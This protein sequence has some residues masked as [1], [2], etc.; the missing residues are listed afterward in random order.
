[1]S[2]QAYDYGELLWVNDEDGASANVD[3]IAAPSDGWKIVIKR[4][5]VNVQ[6][7][8]TVQIGSWDS[9]TF[10][11]KDRHYLSAMGGYEADFGDMP[12]ELEEA[13][14]LRFKKTAATTM[15]YYVQYA[16]VRA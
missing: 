8:D 11:E 5:K 7:Q 2:E 9:P 4:Y 14:G 1:M 12:L 16:I 3:A 15:N 13:T 6:T 10:T